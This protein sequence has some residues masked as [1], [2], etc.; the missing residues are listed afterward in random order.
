VAARVRLISE[1]RLLTT[2]GPGPG[3]SLRHSGE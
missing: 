3:F 1:K 2:D